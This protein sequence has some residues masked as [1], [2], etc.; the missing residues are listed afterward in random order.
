MAWDLLQQSQYTS[1]SDYQKR[2]QFAFLETAQD[3]YTEDPETPN[4]AE[5]LALANQ[6][7]SGS[8]LP[9][10]AFSILHIL[11]PGLQVEG[12][13]PTDND[14]LFT[15]SQQWNYFSGV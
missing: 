2:V 6:V 9:P 8:G 11:N 15:V 14:L 3:V 13:S 1:A 12:G 10:R 5:R 7:I 4:H